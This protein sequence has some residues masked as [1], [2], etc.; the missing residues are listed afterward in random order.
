MSGKTN[1]ADITT[2]ELAGITRLIFFGSLS[3]TSLKGSNLKSGDFAGLTGL[4]TLNLSGNEI[5]TLPADIFSGLSA[6]ESL[7][8]GINQ[9]TTLPSGIFSGLRSLTSLNLSR[10][11]LPASLPASLFADLP[12][13]AT[14]TLPTGTTINA[15]APTTVGTIANITD[16]VAMGSTQTVDVADKFSD[17]DALTFSAESNNIA[18]ATV[19]GSTTI[20]ITPVATGSATI[21]VTATDTA[22]QS[23]TQTFMVSVIPAETDLCSRTEIVKNL[24]ISKMSGKT[25]CADITT[26]E[27]AGVTELSFVGGSSLI[28]SNL[29]SGDFAGLTGLTSLNLSNNEMT[30]LP[31]DIFS[32]LSDLETLRLDNNQL[33]TLPTG[34]FAGLTSLTTL[35][36]SNNPLPASL[37]ARL[38]ADVPATIT[39][40]TGTTINEIPTTVG[41]IDNITNLVAN[42]NTQTVDVADKFSDTDDLTFSAISNDIN[43]ATVGVANDSEVTVT[44]LAAGTATITVT[45]TDIAGQTVEQAFS[46]SVTNPAPT[47]VG[48]MDNMTDLVENGSP[49]T[50][51]VATSFNDPNDTLTFTATSDNTA[52]ATVTVMDSIVTVTPVAVGTT[53]ITVTA[54]DI[55][56]QT[57][58]QTFSVSVTNPAPTATGTIADITHLVANGSPQAVNVASNFSDLDTLTFTATSDD[59]AIAT[60]T[61][62]DSIVTVTPVAAG[63]A[64]ITVTATDRAGQTAEQTFSV[65][66]T[67]PAPTVAGMIDNITDLVENGSPRNVDVASNF[68]DLDTL[69]FS[70]VSSRTAIATVAVMDSIVTVTPVAAGTATITV[71]ATDMAG[72]TAEQTFSVSVQADDVTTGTAGVK[73]ISVSVSPNPLKDGD[74]VRITVANEGVYRLFGSSGEFLTKGTLTKGDNA[75]VFP[76]LAKGIYLLKIQTTHGLMTRKV[77]KK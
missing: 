7:S 61:V 15:A 59:T 1:C 2:A 34:V 37:P 39:L 66:V 6:L 12:A 62:M 25:N 42:G 44:P 68:S 47:T 48:T 16:L 30:T 74:S 43:I 63:T 57:A 76:F 50:V 72:Q 36:L 20:T 33:S 49:Q 22:G 70:A 32:G 45:A 75:V 35:E 73:K 41:T 29:K 21:T 52:I 27:L 71:T 56:G 17:T 38:F 51:N 65:S 13:T 46:V 58:E 14:I 5:T 31:V 64:T 4:T 10:N 28:G 69:T 67:N 3:S 9:L 11:S 18:I 77:V 53:T 19:S 24:I 54:T 40:P 23:V 60:V 55:A 8:L 26:A